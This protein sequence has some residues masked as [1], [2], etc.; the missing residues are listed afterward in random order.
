VKH[1]GLD[2]PW[3]KTFGF[4]LIVNGN[5]HILVPRDFPVCIWD[6]VEEGASDWKDLGS[7]TG[8]TSLRTIDE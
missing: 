5:R 1:V 2:R 8:S 6:F 4:D 3:S 7:K